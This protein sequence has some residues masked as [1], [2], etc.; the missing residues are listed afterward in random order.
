[1]SIGIAPGGLAASGSLA[2]FTPRT[3]AL[4]REMRDGQ[5]RGRRACAG[6]ADWGALLEEFLLGCVACSFPVTY[7]IYLGVEPSPG[8]VGEKRDRRFAFSG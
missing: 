6:A 1:M 7:S 4:G 8:G 3:V 2:S 5:Q